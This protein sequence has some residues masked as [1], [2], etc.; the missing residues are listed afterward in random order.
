MIYTLFSL[1]NGQWSTGILMKFGNSKQRDM[2]HNVISSEKHSLAK[3]INFQAN[4]LQPI[5]TDSCISRLKHK[6]CD[7]T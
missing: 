3:K 6:N 2:K 7:K 4:K 5:N 1:V